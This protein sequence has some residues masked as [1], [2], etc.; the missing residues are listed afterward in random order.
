MGVLGEMF[1][2]KR[3]HE[4][5]DAAQGGQQWRLGPIDL[6]K[7]V[8]SVEAVTAE[9]VGDEAAPQPEEPEREN[10]RGSRENG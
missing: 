8:V 1:P 3:M 2:R 6:D 4:D 5:S 7:G 10:G 9:A